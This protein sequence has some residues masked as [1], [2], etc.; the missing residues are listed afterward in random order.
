MQLVIIVNMFIIQYIS[1][2]FNYTKNSYIYH[3]YVNNTQYEDYELIL[4]NNLPF[5]ML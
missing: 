1:Y 5:I 3:E 4:F 2:A